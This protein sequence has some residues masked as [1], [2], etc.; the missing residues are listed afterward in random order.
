M[1]Q[2]DRRRELLSRGAGGHQRPAGLAKCLPGAG[3][4]RRS[5]R[6]F[7]VPTSTSTMQVCQPVDRGA[8][9]GRDRA[10]LDRA[11]GVK[12][13]I[14]D[15]PTS[16]LSL[17][18][19]QQLRAYVRRQ[20]AE[21]LAFIFISHKLHEIMDVATRV[22]VMRNGRI[23]WEGEDGRRL[24]G[25][26]CLADGRRRD[27][28]R[29]V[30]RR[31]LPRRPARVWPWCVCKAGAGWRNA[32]I[33]LHAGEIIGLAGLEGSGQQEFLHAIFSR[34]REAGVVLESGVTVSFVSGDRAEG[35]R[36][37]AVERAPERLGDA[38]SRPVRSLARRSARRGRGRD[39]RGRAHPSRYRPFPFRHSRP[40]RR[41][42]AKGAG[43]A[44]P[45]VRG[46][47]SS[48]STIPPAAST[49]RQ[50]RTSTRSSPRSR[51]AGR[52]VIWYS[53]EDLE[54]LEC[55]RVLVFSGRAHQ[56]R[57]RRRG[58]RRDSDC[59]RLLRAPAGRATEPDE[60]ARKTRS[61]IGRTTRRGRTV[62]QSGGGPRG[63]GLGQPDVDVVL[64]AGPASVAGPVAGARRARADVHHR[65]QRDRPRRRRLRRRRQRAFGDDPRRVNP[66]SAC[67]RS[68]VSWLSTAD[69]GR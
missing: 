6:C 30:A 68:S 5:R 45:C 3:P 17:D 58:D 16:S 40:Q 69:S 2:S 64:R 57:A 32:E 7:P 46:A 12:I 66:G 42:S 35:G 59:R 39:A 36:V 23:V 13:I 19:S 10:C 67:F 33:T 21:G 37:S 1:Q 53:T 20:A 27:L 38:H 22:A 63:N 56:A 8:A 48:C 52:L 62:R 26:A 44:R 41:K 4:R 9:D 54:F 47:R 11:P 55:D 31:R 24:G 29:A 34:S 14:L 50:S 18:R 60:P 15:E 61:R 25:K 43:G 65:R 28:G 49:S 51:G